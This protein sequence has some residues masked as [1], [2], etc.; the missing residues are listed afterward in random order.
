MT[1]GKHNMDRMPLWEPGLDLTLND[2][3]NPVVVW[4][5]CERFW[6]Y[7]HGSLNGYIVEETTRSIDDNFS[8]LEFIVRPP[9]TQ[10]A[11]VEAM[12]ERRVDYSGKHPRAQRS[13]T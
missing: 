8:A 12:L 13:K 10:K 7:P 5:A 9:T 1:Q 6:D 2:M 3:R 4:R 11:S